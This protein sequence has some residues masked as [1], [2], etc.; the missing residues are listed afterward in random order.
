MLLKENFL[1]VNCDLANKNILAIILEK[2]Y[3]KI[4]KG[5]KSLLGINL[6]NY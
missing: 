4:L 1:D 3:F 6:L 5:N 2:K